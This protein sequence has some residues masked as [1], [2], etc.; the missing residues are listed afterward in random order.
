MDAN[1]EPTTLDGNLLRLEPLSESSANA[2]YHVGKD[3]DVW[4]WMSRPEFSSLSDTERWIEHASHLE[5][6]GEQVPFAIIDSA[7]EIAVGSTRFLSIDVANESIEIGY[8]WL[9]SQYWNS[10]FNTEAKYLM[11]RHAFEQW[12]FNRVQ[13]LTDQRNIRSQKALAGLGA[14]LEGTIRQHRIMYDGHRRSSMIYSILKA[15]W[16]EVEDRLRTKLNAA[17]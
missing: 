1:I 3:P 17:R 10:L 14:Q 2:L 11:L 8:T 4:T 5:L 6:L 15:E 7:K 9:A 16:P 12:G 13:F